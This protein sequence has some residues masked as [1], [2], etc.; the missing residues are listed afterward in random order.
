MPTVVRIHVPPH[1]EGGPNL[2]LRGPGALFV[3]SFER[4]AALARSPVVSAGLTDPERETAVEYCLTIAHQYRAHS[5]R[6]WVSWAQPGV[7]D[8]IAPPDDGGDDDGVSTDDLPV[9]LEVLRELGLTE[10]EI[11]DAIRSRP[12]VFAAHST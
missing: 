3:R 8:R 2:R 10:A 1:R 12:L 6:W 4:C 5:A 11:A 9:P 7:G